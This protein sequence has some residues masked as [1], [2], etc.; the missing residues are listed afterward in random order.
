MEM[1]VLKF[2]RGKKS[3]AGQT[4][5]RVARVR[6]L[7][8]ESAQQHKRLTQSSTVNLVLLDPPTRPIPRD[9]SARFKHRQAQA[10]C[11]AD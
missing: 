2:W 9:P 1:V 7:V 11:R 10:Q 5:A 4:V 8:T 3:G 6:T